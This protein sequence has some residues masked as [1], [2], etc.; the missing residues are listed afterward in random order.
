MKNSQWVTFNS[1]SLRALPLTLA[2]KEECP[3][4]PPLFNIVLK[5][6]AKAIK[7][8]K[9]I[10]DFPG[11]TVVKN[12]SANAGDTGSNPAPGRSHMLQRN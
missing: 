12:P 1:E 4:S 6:L 5:V 9:E 8:E 2:T 3:L 11:G 10:R 7:Q